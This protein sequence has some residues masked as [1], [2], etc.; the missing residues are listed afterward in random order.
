MVALVSKYRYDGNEVNATL[1]KTEADVLHDYLKDTNAKNYEEVIRILSTRSKPQLV[2]TFNR[3]RDD[4]CTSLTKV[5]I[6]I[7]IHALKAYAD[8]E[9]RKHTY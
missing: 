3:Y 9:E 7:H 1:A 2:A 5:C 8:V 4:H 6:Y